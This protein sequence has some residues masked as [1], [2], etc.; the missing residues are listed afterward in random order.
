MK[1]FEKVA[2]NIDVLPLLMALHT[3]PQLWGQE[4]YRKDTPGTPHTGMTDIWVRYNDITK[5]KE[6]GDFTNF[7]GPHI[8][9][10]Y[11]AYD[12]LPHIRPIA[13]GLMARFQAVGLGGILITKIPPGGRVEP[14]IDEGWHAEF[15]NTKLYVV[16]Q[17][18]PYCRNRVGDEVVFMKTGEVWY[19]DNSVEH[20]VINEGT[21]DRITLII[22]MR[23]DR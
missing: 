1:H 11:P 23:C 8:S 17:S 20:E 6:S 16:L 15:Y 13:F 10:W 22:C 19:F 18:N 2:D 4:G 21:D 12:H 14:H 9:K 7:N 3:N 5:Y